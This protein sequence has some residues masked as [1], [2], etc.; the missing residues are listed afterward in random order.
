LEA[1]ISDWVTYFEQYDAAIS[2]PRN[3]ALVYVSTVSRDAGALS[4]GADADRRARDA[5]GAGGHVGSELPTASV[6]G[7]VNGAYA[8]GVKALRGGPVGRP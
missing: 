1:D 5:G 4:A 3:H 6:M 2:R 7:W 8:A